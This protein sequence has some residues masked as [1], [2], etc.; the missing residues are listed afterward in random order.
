MIEMMK[1]DMG[2][3]ACT[4]GAAKVREQKDK[5]VHTLPKQLCSVAY[6]NASRSF[7]H[8]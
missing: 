5:H 2:G 6:N 3:S 4:L 8:V 7:A 1:F